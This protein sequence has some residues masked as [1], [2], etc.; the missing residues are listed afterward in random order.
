M[1][2]LI[3]EANTVTAKT[4]TAPLKARGFVVDHTDNGA[5]ALELVRRYDYDAVIIAIGLPDFGGCEV[6]RR[7]RAARIDTPVLIVSGPSRLHVIT[8]LDSGADDCIAGSIDGAELLARVRAVVR[9]S[10]G[11]SRQTIEIGPLTLDIG[12]RC[13]MVNDETVSL[14]PKEYA[15][16]ELLCMRKGMVLRKETFLD[17]IYGA[18]DDEPEIR[19]IDVYVCNLRRKLALA[20]APDMIV[21]ARGQGIVLREPSRAARLPGFRP[22]AEL[23]LEAA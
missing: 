5:E 20:G 19:I 13:A 3:A 4:L 6:V 17:H 15:I 23:S 22:A 14:T 2:V 9:R 8:A 16:L 12:G 7:M 18:D 21:T 11:L 10:K 1:R